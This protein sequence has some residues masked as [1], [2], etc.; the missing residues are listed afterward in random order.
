MEIIEMPEG[1]RVGFRC[2]CGMALAVPGLSLVGGESIEA[3]KRRLMGEDWK[4]TVSHL[5]CALGAKQITCTPDKLILLHPT[6]TS[7]RTKAQL[8]QVRACVRE[9]APLM[10]LTEQS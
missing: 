3:G 6:K 4:L 7:N 1:G 5:G 2:K 8:A 9:P 10:R